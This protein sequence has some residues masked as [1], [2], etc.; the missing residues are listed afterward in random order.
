M[1]L[2]S[3]ILWHAVFAAALMTAGAAVAAAQQPATQP[4]NQAPGPFQ[5]M[6]VNRD[7]PIQINA[8]TLE[9]RDKEKKATFI[10]KVVVVQG[11]TTLKCNKLDVFYEQNAAAGDA[12]KTAPKPAPTPAGAGPGGGQQQIQRLEARGNVVVIQKEQT[13]TGDTA[14]YELK[15][16]SV[17]LNGNATVTQGQNV[18]R[19]DRIEVD[20]LT[21]VTQVKSKTEGESGVSGLLFPNSTKNPAKTDADK[22]GA[23]KDAAKDTPKTA[24]KQAR[25]Q[26]LKLN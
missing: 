1:M 12:A 13:A 25:K 10:G 17:T 9:V 11:E 22:S 26:P 21:G 14:I 4:A 7:K 3:R 19:G 18:I 16:N 2:R 24:P 8:T 6:Q 5:G 15:T 23:N 20:L